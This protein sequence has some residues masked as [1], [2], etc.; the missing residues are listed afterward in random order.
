MAGRFAAVTWTRSQIPTA[1][2]LS[3]MSM[4]F[5]QIRSKEP[6]PSRRTLVWSWKTG[7]PSSV[8]WYQRTPRSNSARAIFP[9]SR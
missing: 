5:D 7:G 4:R 3:L 1:R 8:T 9:S 2:S 6:P